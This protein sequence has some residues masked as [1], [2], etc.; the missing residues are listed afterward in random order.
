MSFSFR[1]RYISGLIPTAQKIDS[2]WNELF[3]MRDELHQ[4]ETSKELAR[5]QELDQLVHS[6]NFKTTKRET[7]NLSF[8]ASSACKVLTELA[9]LEQ[10][11]QIK[12]YFKFLQLP[13]L[14]RI[15]KIAGSSEFLRYLELKKIVGS[16]D[17]IR[18]KKEVESLRFKGSPEY[19]KSHNYNTLQNNSR[20]KRCHSTLAS[21]EYRLF[22]ELEVSEKEKLN[23]PSSKKDLKIKIYRKF[24]N[25][26]AYK[27]LKAVEK[28]GLQAQLDQL[29]QEINA[30]PFLDREAFLKNPA[31]Y[32][33]TPDYP[34][35]DEFTKLS[36][37]SDIQFYLKCIIS[38]LYIN[39]QKIV[40]S[41]ELTRLNELR[42]KVGVP[43]FI[44]Q[45]IFLKNKKRYETT[46]Q[47]K[48]EKEFSELEKSK[49]IT[50]YHQLKKQSAL[51][52]FE[53]WEVVLDENFSEH[54]LAPTLWEPEN[55]WG[56]KMAGCSFSQSNELQAYKG[57][58]NVEIRN[59]VL[60]IVT[61]AEKSEGKV[62]D[63]IVGLIPR[64]FDYSSAILNTG[65]YFKFKEGV[66][67]AK[68][69]FRAEKA[70]TSAFSLTGSQPFPQI[71]VFRSGNNS[72]GL[73]IIEQPGKGSLKKIVQIKGLNYNNFHIF[74][75][76]VS[77]NLL[78]WK[79]NNHE[80]HR[81]QL[82]RNIGEL[83]IN[84]IGSLHQPLNGTSLP[85]HFEIDWVRCLKKKSSKIQE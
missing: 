27:N 70:I 4:I 25:S 61:R 32:E 48:L 1:L 43:E 60:S 36:K 2:A 41:K 19:I 84:F 26:R 11:I 63:P 51:K 74:R 52:F 14:E 64:K 58:K 22:L 29:K 80:V 20:L 33:T 73:G 18:R 76:E 68:V 12:D 23:D 78:V 8:K 56:S 67:E 54:Q 28:L 83:F 49:I 66:V 44:Q 17:F 42:L 37:N 9:K 35:F 46:P 62:W 50:T 85:H 47:Y 65:N 15:N 77:G 75:L 10:S 55:Y 16:P 6:G 82:T 72:V 81:E 39:Y 30:K 3:R 45:V 53:H 79:I 24:L 31:R 13:D 7:I 5:Y 34:Q 71:D 57:L 40:A 21:D 59:N 69:K 38:P